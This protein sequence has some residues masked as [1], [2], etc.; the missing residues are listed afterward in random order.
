MLAQDMTDRVQ[1][2]NKEAG[3]VSPE[4]ITKAEEAIEKARIALRDEAQ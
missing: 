4:E 3:D 2:S 1:E